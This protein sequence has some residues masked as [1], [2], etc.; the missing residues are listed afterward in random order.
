[1]KLVWHLFRKDLARVKF[2]VA[3]LLLLVA[4]RPLLGLIALAQDNFT[5]DEATRYEDLDAV[6]LLLQVVGSWLLTLWLARLDSPRRPDVFLHTRPVSRRALWSAKLLGAWALCAFAPLLVWLPWWLGCGMGG[7]ELRA[8]VITHVAGPALLVTPALVIGSLVGDYRRAVLWSVAFVVVVMCLPVLFSH[9]GESQWRPFSN[10]AWTL[11][12]GVWV[13]FGLASALVLLGLLHRRHPRW[14]G[15]AAWA[16]ATFVLGLGFHKLPWP[17]PAS[18]AASD[19]SARSMPDHDSTPWSEHDAAAFPDLRIEVASLKHRQHERAHTPPYTVFN[20][21]NFFTLDVRVTGAPGL[22]IDTEIEAITF[23]ARDGT[24]MRIEHD[25]LLGAPADQYGAAFAPPPSGPAPAAPPTS[26][27]LRRVWDDETADQLAALVGPLT[28][29]ADLRLTLRRP[30]LL[31]RHPL[32]PGG[33]HRDGGGI[34]RIR[35]LRK[36]TTRPSEFELHQIRTTFS[37]SSAWS[38]WTRFDD[39]LDPRRRRLGAFNSQG[40][41]ITIYYASGYPNYTV[42][43]VEIDHTTELLEPHYTPSP[44]GFSTRPTPT[45]EWLA[46]LSYANVRFD[47][48]ARLRRELHA[49]DLIVERI[50]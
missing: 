13:L 15:F 50:D 42:A 47:P 33:W 32:E 40:H 22:A 31:A 37:N 49:T 18:R 34:Y 14:T 27:V 4:L 25:F 36:S 17:G 20:L 24:S 8:L 5:H 10:R 7:P 35:S 9:P 29:H 6:L 3:A 46:G 41:P 2:L 30:V 26:V 38:L 23:T 1:M 28:V 44:D 21:H 45:R 11:R 16:A 39:R 48:V 43:G 12:L 19:R